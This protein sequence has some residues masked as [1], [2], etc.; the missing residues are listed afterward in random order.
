MRLIY[1]LY[2]LEPASRRFKSFSDNQVLASI[3][4]YLCEE[5]QIDSMI[6]MTKT[7]RPSMEG[8]IEDIEKRFPPCDEFD[9]EFHHRHRQVL[10]SMIRYI[11]GHHGYWPGKAKNMK[12]GRYI[13][14]AIVYSLQARAIKSLASD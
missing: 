7:K 13:K 1:Q 10:G 12:K 5:T 2:L 11:M 9:L 8:V 6:E 14:T 4:N 3:F